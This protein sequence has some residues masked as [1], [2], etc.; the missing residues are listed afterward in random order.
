VSEENR[1]KFLN[2]LNNPS[3]RSSSHTS[4]RSGLTNQSSSKGSTQSKLNSV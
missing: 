2:Y 1:N 3:D 4:N